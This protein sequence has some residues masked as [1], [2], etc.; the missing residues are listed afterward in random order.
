LSPFKILLDDARS[1]ARERGNSVLHLGG[2]RGGR[3]DELLMFKGEFSPRRHLFCV[4][5]WVLDKGAYRDLVEARLTAA[6]AGRVPDPTFFP[7]YRA[8]FLD[9]EGSATPPLLP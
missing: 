9:E 5:R 7:A 4:G 8:P 1:W 2:G 3:K 6:P